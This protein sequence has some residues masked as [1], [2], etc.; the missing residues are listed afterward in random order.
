MTPRE[1]VIEAMAQADERTSLMTLTPTQRAALEWLPKN[2]SWSGWGRYKLSSF[3]ALER[4]G[5]VAPTY[6]AF[7]GDFSWRITPAGVKALMEAQV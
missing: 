7:Y 3:L 1:T 2:G 6:D 4:K 5:Y